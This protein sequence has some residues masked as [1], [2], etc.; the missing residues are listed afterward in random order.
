MQET[1][2]RTGTERRRTLAEQVSGALRA[3]ILA[4]DLAPGSRLP[5]EPGLVAEFGVSRTVIREAIA[6]L[7]ADGLVVPRQGVGVFVTERP[8]PPPP[9]PEPDIPERLSSIIEMLELRAGVEIEAAGLAA[10]R[11]SPGQVARI[12]EALAEIG[13]AMDRGE[14]AEGPD[15]AFH[16]TIMEATNNRLFPDFLRSLGR[17]A[18]PRAHVADPAGLPEGYLAQIQAEHGGIVAA[19]AEGDA[20]AAREGMRRHLKGSLARYESR[21]AA[22]R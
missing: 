19:I 21:L 10:K 16:L 15:L 5:P 11:A 20:E 12:R 3:R 7:R 1:E 14:R 17:R 2:D 22:L 6:G 18:I 9:V 4:G 8:A 13:R